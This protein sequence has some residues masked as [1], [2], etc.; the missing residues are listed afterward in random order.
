M[1]SKPC[2][3]TSVAETARQ[4]FMARA[5]HAP[6]LGKQLARGGLKKAGIFLTGN[7]NGSIIL[8]TIPVTLTITL[9]GVIPPCHNVSPW[10]MSP[11]KPAYL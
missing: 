10:S 9:T 11:V 4:G 7:S 2:K 6:A 5:I 3:S 8:L 1:F